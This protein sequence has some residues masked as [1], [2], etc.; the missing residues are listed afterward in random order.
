MDVGVYIYRLLGVILGFVF[1]DIWGVQAIRP[2]P[3]PKS[4]LPPK[5]Y[6]VVRT[7][8]QPMIGCARAVA[9]TKACVSE[10]NITLDTQTHCASMRAHHLML[11][12]QSSE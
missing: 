10:L 3:A 12:E 6:D 8:Y 7:T 1:E 11:K 2:T 5:L 9:T 4:L